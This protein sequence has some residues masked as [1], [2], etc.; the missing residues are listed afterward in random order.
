MSNILYLIDIREYIEQINKNF[1]N[2]EKI[3]D[4]LDKLIRAKVDPEDLV[5][6][7]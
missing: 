5:V 4:I 3:K 1:E 2:D 6:S 7:K